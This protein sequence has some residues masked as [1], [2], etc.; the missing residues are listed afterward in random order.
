MSKNVGKIVCS[1]YISIRISDN[2]T[3]SNIIKA[4]DIQLTDIEKYVSQYSD[5]PDRL[6]INHQFDI[7]YI[8]T[9][10]KNIYNING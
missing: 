4:A 1:N 5:E 9:L 10:L 8:N 2:Y 6:Y 7:N 3:I